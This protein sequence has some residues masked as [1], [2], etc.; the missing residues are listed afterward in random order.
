MCCQLPPTNCNHPQPN[1][2]GLI[3][4]PCETKLKSYWY[5][6][7][8]EYAHSI[9]TF[10]FF[11]CLAFLLNVLLKNLLLATFCLL[12]K[13]VRKQEVAST[14]LYRFARPVYRVMHWQGQVIHN[15]WP[16]EVT[17]VF[18]CGDGAVTEIIKMQHLPFTSQLQAI[19]KKKLLPTSP[20][21]KKDF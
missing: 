18:L 5:L 4:P 19:K 21:T 15:T 16:K 6:N 1:S 7:V 8:V 3:R 9:S 17:I 13:D 2:K 12:N 10:K 11:L 20:P 14:M